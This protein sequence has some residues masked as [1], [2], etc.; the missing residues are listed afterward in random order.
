VQHHR[1]E[2]SL[3]E[4]YTPIPEPDEHMFRPHPDSIHDYI[5]NLVSVFN[6]TPSTM[7]ISF[8][9]RDLDTDRSPL[10][11]SSSS[12]SISLTSSKKS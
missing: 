1:R 4:N 10:M 5:D 8:R 11:A 9:K 6:E 12:R 2:S 7:N 3:K